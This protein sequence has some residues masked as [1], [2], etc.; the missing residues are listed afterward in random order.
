MAST[1]SPR[2]DDALAYASRLDADH[3]Q[4]DTASPYDSHLLADRSC[5]STVREHVLPLHCYKSIWTPAQWAIGIMSRV[6]VGP[7]KA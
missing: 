3:L 2:F 5:W 1:L 7:R 6:R 4:K